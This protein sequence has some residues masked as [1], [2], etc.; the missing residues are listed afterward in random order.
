[1]LDSYP[2]SQASGRGVKCNRCDQVLIL[3]TDFSNLN[4][5]EGGALLIEDSNSISIAKSSFQSNTALTQG[6]ATLLL[7][8]QSFTASEVQWLN[9]TAK[10]GGAF[11][12][13]DTDTISLSNST[14]DSNVANNTGG[15][16]HILNTGSL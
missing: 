7:D 3:N 15:A 11:S 10:Q 16:T 6:G 5:K 14:F 12:A 2:D 8:T 13:E 4:A 1:M 9:N